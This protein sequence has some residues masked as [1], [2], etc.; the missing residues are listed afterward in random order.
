[1][2]LLKLFFRTIF[3]NP[4]FYFLLVSVA[5][6]IQIIIS[7]FALRIRS[8]LFKNSQGLISIVFF[9][10]IVA[11]VSALPGSWFLSNIVGFTFNNEELQLV[12]IIFL[13]WYLIFGIPHFFVLYRFIKKTPASE[14]WRPSD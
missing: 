4:I 7:Y 5:I 8:Y 6:I 2:E 14:S 1:M 3:D 9:S 11:M 13:Y 10:G 12:K